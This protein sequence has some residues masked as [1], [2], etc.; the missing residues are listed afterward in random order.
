MVRNTSTNTYTV[1][2]TGTFSTDG[3][4]YFYSDVTVDSGAN[5]DV[6]VAAYNSVSTAVN[7][8]S[9]SY[10]SLPNYHTG[11]NASVL[12]IFPQLT[13]AFFLDRTDRD[14]LKPRNTSIITLPANGGPASWSISKIQGEAYSASGTTSDPGS[15]T[16][17]YNLSSAPS[18]AISITT[19]PTSGLL[20]YRLTATNWGST[21]T[22]DAP[23]VNTAWAPK[24]TNL[25]TFTV[26]QSTTKIGAVD[27]SFRYSAV[28]SSNTNNYAV[29]KD[30]L[31]TLIANYELAAGVTGTTQSI[32]ASGYTANSL[33]TF[34]VY[35]Y[36][37]SGY[38][39]TSKSEKA[40]DYI[41]P[42]GYINVSSNAAGVISFAGSVTAPAD[43]GTTYW[44]ISRASGG[45]VS[46]GSVSAGSTQNLGLL[47]ITTNWS[48]TEGLLRYELH[49]S[50]SSSSTG[51]DFDPMPTPE[52][53]P[54]ST[55]VIAFDA[56]PS[57]TSGSIDM[58]LRY[59]ARSG[60]GENGY[61]FAR[62]VR[63]T[64]P[65]DT[66]VYASYQA[67]GTTSSILY[68]TDSNLTPGAEHT[69]TLY[70]YNYAGYYSVAATT[71]AGVTPPT[72]SVAA[73]VSGYSI[74]LSYAVD[75]PALCGD[76]VWTITRSDGDEITAG[77]VPAGSSI[78]ET[79]ID[80]TG[81]AGTSYT[82]TIGA[83]NDSTI[84]A[85]YTST[86]VTA[87][88]IPL[89][90]YSETIG[91]SERSPFTGA[92]TA[93]TDY[94]S[95]VTFNVGHVSGA[96]DG[97]D[98]VTVKPIHVNSAS[99]HF[100]SGGSGTVQL[101]MDDRAN[102]TQATR[103]H[104]WTSSTNN[105]AL[106][107][108]PDADTDKVLSFT[109]RNAAGR[110]LLTFTGEKWYAGF[111]MISGASVLFYRAPGDSGTNITGD[112]IIYRDG[113]NYNATFGTPASNMYID[114]KWRTVPSSPTGVAADIGANDPSTEIDVTWNMPL[115]N[116][117]V[118][119]TGY[120]ILYKE[121]DG[122]WI[123]TGKITGV[124][125]G[126]YTITGLT[127][128]ATYE[129]V[130][131]AVNLVSD[132][133]NNGTSTYNYDDAS[134]HTGTNSEILSVTT[135][136]TAVPVGTKVAVASK[137][138]SNTAVVAN[139]FLFTTSTVH[140]LVPKDI[141]TISL[142]DHFL[143]AT[144]TPP[145]FDGIY[146]VST[147]PSTTTFTVVPETAPDEPDSGPYAPDSPGTV[148][149]W[150]ISTMNVKKTSGWVAATVVKIYDE[151]A[152]PTPAWVDKL[153]PPVV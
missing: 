139:K 150:K 25:L 50:N 153:P 54:L 10:Y 118:A 86:A 92:D 111:R 36:N 48:P 129:V 21:V 90:G 16:G 126:E 100:R 127:P 42:Y 18:P 76:T 124:S 52:A 89:L 102:P 29:I 49:M 69:Y 22:V 19:T 74:Q 95:G 87:P 108:D 39:T 104:Q 78:T 46:S 83:Y 143:E 93:N 17:S 40:G 32:E 137:S 82:Y 145:A 1:K 113:V 136:L 64:N 122:E 144:T 7:G 44:Y 2:A 109:P 81:V 131:A 33:R 26:T 121:T 148:I 3:S 147:T 11:T 12:S 152:D 72:A 60:A 146:Y 132:Y 85:I 80:D 130:I 28:G 119:V 94:T 56:E 58:L 13:A 101:Q 91:G 116:G 71:T 6:F 140:G 43:S 114:F 63:G 8:G 135:Q 141:V 88:A 149:K 99:V 70:I 73:S 103:Y 34:Y 115:S 128:G 5:Y 84:V 97:T 15:S 67:E 53:P 133:H 107:K 37:N 75:S 62:V 14:T 123:S 66:E 4:G 41:A 77:T 79:Y 24:S 138:I 117:G 134:D 142:D 35:L 125:T 51:L 61:T 105:A 120:R 151:A 59:S 112:N 23:S 96:F 45:N 47:N 9:T 55:N 31:G 57:A 65:T 110:Y 38:Y 27:I 30:D 98:F 20:Q 106:T 68:F